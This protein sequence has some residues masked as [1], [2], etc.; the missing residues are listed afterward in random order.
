MRIFMALYLLSAALGAAQPQQTIS[1]FGEAEV[2]VPPD[3]VNVYLGVEVRSKDLAFARQRNDDLVKAVL[4]VPR[5]F[6]IAAEDVQTDFAQVGMEYE[7]DGLTL[8]YYSVRKTINVL[9][10]DISKFEPFLSAALDA[11]ATHLHGVEFSTSELRMHRDEA[12]ALAVKA[13][14]EKARDLALAAGRKA[15]RAL[16]ISAHFGGGSWYGYGWS[17]GRH[18]YQQQNV[19]QYSGGGGGAGAGAGS[20]SLGRIS[21]TASVGMTF[22]L[23]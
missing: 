13:A 19:V 22:E 23:E 6:G 10:R 2:K 16:T 20:V 4:A 5:R 18:S 7:I 11:G 9:M 3:R 21:V 8:K 12:R 14:N 17:G 15:G 1:V